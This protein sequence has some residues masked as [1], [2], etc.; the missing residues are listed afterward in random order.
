M[1][2]TL[3]TAVGGI[4]AALTVGAT[5]LLHI[6]RY[7]YKQGVTDTRIKALEDHSRDGASANAAISALNVAVAGL[8]ATV[9]ALKDAMDRLDEAIKARLD[10]LDR[11]LDEG[12]RSRRSAPS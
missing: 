5:L 1:D 12:S 9:T 7:A 8:S 2:T 11:R 10:Q 3:W 4:A 6:I